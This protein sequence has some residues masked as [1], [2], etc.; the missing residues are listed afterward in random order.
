MDGR[1]ERPLDSGAMLEPDRPTPAG[2]APAGS[3]TR[4]TAAQNPRADAKTARPKVVYVMGSGHSGSTI[5]SVTLGNCEGWFYA[6]ELQNFLSRA[7]TPVLGGIARTRFWGGVRDAVPEAEELF[8]NAPHRLI[9]RS[10]ATLRFTNWPARRRMRPRYRRVTEKLF[11]AI[12]GAADATHVIDSSHFP[13]RARELQGIAGI[14]LYLIFLVRD[15]Q[16]VVPSI[17]RLINRNDVVARHLGV[18]R[19]NA[20]L[21][22][23][24]VLSLW[25]FRRQPAARRIFVRY[26]D[27]IA[28]PEQVVARILRCADSDASVPDL[29]ELSTGFPIHANRLIRAETVALRGEDG[30]R[31]A[32]SRVTALLQRPWT[33]LFARMQA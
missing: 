2:G 1:D 25:V 5:L 24:H 27:F 6:G 14:D 12:A 19:R 29:G 30:E 15:P 21:W 33:R 3:A 9:E 18:L 28:R 23:T 11:H 17:N 20:D 26:E 10:M 7:G 8:G 16:R 4:A 31:P 13:L 32:H 22:L